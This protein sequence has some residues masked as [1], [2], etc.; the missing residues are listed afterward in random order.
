MTETETGLDRVSPRWDRRERHRLRIEGEPAA[1]IQA[2]EDLTWGEVPKFRR[3]MVIAGLGRVPFRKDR[4]VVTMFLDNDFRILHRSDDELVIGG[5]QRISRK[6]PIA[7]MG[8][9]PATE[10]RDFDRPSH[11]LTCF[12]FRYQDGVLVTETRVR[13]TSSRARRLFAVYWLVIRA[14]SGLIRRIWLRG[15][16]R[17]MAATAS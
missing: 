11:L 16:R 2:A 10:F 4:Q 6:Q 9:D 13:A 15:V 7:P 8:D 12:N 1:V 17:R 3:I 14:G 5:I